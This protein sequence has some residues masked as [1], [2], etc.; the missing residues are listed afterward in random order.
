MTHAADPRPQAPRLPLAESPVI[1][2]VAPNG[3]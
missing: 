1:I 2:T 3:A